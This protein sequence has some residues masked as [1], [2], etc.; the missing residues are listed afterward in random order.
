VQIDS[1]EAGEV[2]E[3]AFGISADA[4][5]KKRNGNHDG[6]AIWSVS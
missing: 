6:K 4:C 1:Q 2:M 3:D 5:W